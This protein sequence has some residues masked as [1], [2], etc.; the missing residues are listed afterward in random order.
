MSRSTS[1]VLAALATLAALAATYLAV[2]VAAYDSSP[3][4][5]RTWGGISAGAELRMWAGDPL[6]VG[7][8]VLAVVMFAAAWALTAR[9]VRR[10]Q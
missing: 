4:W 8:T 10:A 7:A 2:N 5:A 1:R 6:V 9:V 3:E